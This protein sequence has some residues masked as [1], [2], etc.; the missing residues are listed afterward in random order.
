MGLHRVRP[1]GQREPQPEPP[2]SLLRGP[3]PRA[4]QRGLQSP[5]ILF[6]RGAQSIMSHPVTAAGTITFW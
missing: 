1:R 4:G 5:S 3:Q 2:A 6:S